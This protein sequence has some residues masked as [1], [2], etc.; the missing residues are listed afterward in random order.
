M[1]LSKRLNEIC[2][3]VSKE[4][5][6]ADVGSDH[7]KVVAKL[8]LD[9]K[10]DYAFVTDIS[11]PS[12]KKAENLLI[13]LNIDKSKYKIVVCDGGDNIKTKLKIIDAIKTLVDVD[14]LNIQVYKT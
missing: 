2:D 12:V 14:D 11:A 4:S 10:I 1:K 13:D 7:G 8:F 9:N 3:L 6:I 5:V